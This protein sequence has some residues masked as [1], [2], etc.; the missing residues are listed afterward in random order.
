MVSKVLPAVQENCSLLSA[1]VSHSKHVG[2]SCDDLW[3]N[4]CQKRDEC[5]EKIKKMKG[6]AFF[7]S[8]V[9]AVEKRS[10]E[11]GKGETSSSQEQENDQND[12]LPEK[13][14]PAISYWIAVQSSNGMRVST[15]PLHSALLQTGM[16]VTAKALPVCKRGKEEESCAPLCTTLKDHSNQFIQNKVD[17]SFS[18]TLKLLQDQLIEEPLEPLHATERAVR[19]QVVCNLFNAKLRDKLIPSLVSSGLQFDVFGIEACHLHSDEPQVTKALA[20][21]IV[22]VMNDIERAMIKLGY[23]LYSGEV[24]KKVKNSK[25]TYQHCCSVKK[26]LSLLGSNDNFKDSIIKHLNKLVEILGDKECEFMKQLRINY[27]LIEV[28]GGWCFSISQRKFVL[29]PI[30][31]TDI[32]KESPRAHIEYEHTKVPDPGYFQQILQNSLDQLEISHFC[33]YYIRLLNCRIKQHKEK[34]MCLIGEPN[35]GKTSLFTPISRLIPARYIA[36]ISKQKAFNKSLVDE[37]TQIIFLDEAHPKLMDPDDW[38][39]LTQ[40][41]LTAHDRKYK[42]SNLAVI[43]CPMFITCQTDMDFGQEHNNAM[44]ARLMK[45]FLKRLTSPRVPG[46]QE[47]LR[48]NAMDCIVWACGLARTPDDELPPPVP[49]TSLQPDVIDEEEK[50]R[51]RAVQLDESE[52]DQE[53]SAQVEPN[54]ALEDSD[55]EEEG[56]VSGTD[57]TCLDP[58]EK[59]LEEIAHLR[60]QQPCHSLKQRQLALLGAEVRRTI[61]ER[62]SQEEHARLRVLEETKERWISLDMI[63][64]EDAHL[65]ESFNGPF[66]PNIERSREEYFARKR[67]EDQRV[68]EKKAGEYFNNE[69][70]MEKERELRDFQTREDAATDEDVK[71]ALQYMIEVT[72][73]ALQL[74][75]KK[76]EMSGLAK[77]VLLERRKRAVE[78]QW[79]S[80]SQAQLINSIWCPL[81][82]PCEEMEEGEDESLFITPSTATKAHGSLSTQRQKS[83]KRR[84]QQ[85]APPVPKRG[86]ITHFFTSSQQ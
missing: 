82:F 55:L 12:E 58:F 21:P 17:T 30:K 44:D 32:G 18:H 79:V 65:L 86:R 80:M 15:V 36:M 57:S 74:N 46:V 50:E 7:F 70:V 4:I 66:H 37:N 60:E 6:V 67:E 53:D 16:E 49:R 2:L 38:K 33:E 8:S 78:M 11:K 25:Y 1:K 35:S 68:L 34:V 75:F 56:Q 64:E 3:L 42:T 84:S 28:N 22:V 5:D 77:L 31:D 69:W 47:F 61:D 59:S 81:P 14:W 72:V 52:S 73:E 51:I 45:F 63:R 19:L 9:A 39:I 85:T 23:A 20:S 48:A 26:F 13:Y 76:E 41:G 43:R 83:Q 10:K 71:R 29:H 24:F 62:D 40:G 27:D 54:T